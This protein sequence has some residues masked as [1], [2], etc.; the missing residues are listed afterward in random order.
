[1]SRLNRYNDFYLRQMAAKRAQK[2]NFINDLKLREFESICME[3]KKHDVVTLHLKNGSK[4]NESYSLILEDKEIL[5]ETKKI[6][7]VNFYKDRLKSI[8]K[9]ARVYLEKRNIPES[10]I[11]IIE[12]NIELMFVNE[13]RLKNFFK[14]VGDKIGQA[15][16]YVEDKLSSGLKWLSDK[17]A[18]VW[19]SIIEDIIKPG[20]DA[21]K[22]VATKLFGAEIVAQIETVAKKAINAFDD[23]MNKTAS[24]FDKVYTKLKDI[25]KN[26]VNIVKDMWNKL[27]ELLKKVWE[28]IKKHAMSVLPGMKS[29][30]AKM[31]KLEG[32]I[33]PG[34]LGTE[35][36]TVVGDLSEIG[37]YFLGDPKVTTV[38]MDELALSSGKNILSGEAGE[39]E[40]ESEGE[41]KKESSE[42]KEL[43][44]DSFIWDSM[45][46]YMSKGE[47]FD[48]DEL[49]R[50][51]ETKEERIYEAEENK[52]EDTAD[53][54]IDDIKKDAKKKESRGIKKWIGGIVMW[55]LS[56]IG[57]LAEVI[58][59]VVSKGM[60]AMPAWLSGKL[61]TLYEGVKNMISYASKFKAIGTLAQFIM[62]IAAAGFALSSKIPG[63]WLKSAEHALGLEGAVEK[64]NEILADVGRG[65]EKTI[66]GEIA[67]L[68]TE[69]RLHKFDQ[70]NKINESEG[71]DTKGLSFKGLAVAAGSA[72]LGFLI[73]VFTHSIPFVHVGFE[74]ISLTL[75]IFA[76]IGFIFTQLEFGKEIAQKNGFGEWCKKIY[77]F[78]HPH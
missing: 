59:D 24:V 20:L 18:A 21:L 8:A 19:D 74:A 69:S 37:I 9:E 49:I 28:F 10:D 45:K 61:G 60:S 11:R 48:T 3:G 29:K 77:N 51:H 2:T 25:A 70:F 5:G 72:L 50:L 62:G 76:T 15:A 13:G 56:P 64:G 7:C 14:K 36:K 40:G 54:T 34:Q 41:E 78:I 46:G 43:V 35:I 17:A 42:K 16:D 47:N 71:G 73:S 55:L 68:K 30:L 65:V 23:L 53:D 31:K 1:M 27:K 57:K 75:L 38:Q 52:E 67:N 39:S 26:L 33:N 66:G 12:N 4:V 58:G 44:S 22:N 6:V 63:E 32:E